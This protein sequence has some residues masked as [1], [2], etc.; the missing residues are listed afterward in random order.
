MK[1]Y[2]RLTIYGEY[3]MHGETYGLIEK[4]NLCLATQ[5]HNEVQPHPQYN[6]DRDVVARLIEGLGIKIIPGVKGNLPLGYGFA[7]SSIFSFLYLYP[8]Y[9]ERA[10]EMINNMDKSIH[11]FQPSGLDASF[12]YRQ[13]KGLYRNGEWQDV[14]LARK[15]YSLLTFPKEGKVPL[16]EVS[17]RIARNRHNLKLIAN[18]MTNSIVLDK[19][20]PYE[21]LY[22]YSV[23]LVNC[24][25]YSGH[26]AEFVNFFLSQNI[27]AKGIGGL[28]DKAVLLIWPDDI[29]ALCRE[30]FLSQCLKW[31]PLTIFEDV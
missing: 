17:K 11:G 24:N 28:Y 13:K 20:L 23:E 21:Y 22:K 5:E 30:N 26:V 18:S 8:L 12:C 1:I 29:S 10:Y 9:G 27:V 31:Q 2:G 19:C 6:I 16:S 14:T 25:V 4:S 3:L 7:S 15:S